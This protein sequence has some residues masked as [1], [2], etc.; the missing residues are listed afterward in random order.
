MK[1]I[2][3]SLF[4]SVTSFY[5]F[6]QPD[7]C[8]TPSDLT[9][10]TTCGASTNQSLQNATAVGSPTNVAGTTNDVW[11]TFTTP[12]GITS[13]TIALSSPGSN[14]QSNAYIEAFSAG[15][16]PSGTFSGT[17]R[18]TSAA[19]TASG[20]SLSLTGLTGSTQYHFRV[21]STGNTGSGSGPSWRFSICVSY[22][23][24]PTIS[25]P[26][27]TRMKEVFQQTILA[28][29]AAGL[30][31]PWEITYEDKEDSLWMTE[32]K[33]YK[34]RKM[35]PGTGQ[36]RV[37][38]DLSNTGSFSSF[39]RT[40]TSS[41]NPWP[42]G[43]MM[44][45]AIH[46]QF[47]AA[48]NPKNFV[49]VAYVRAF[50]GA[51]PAGGTRATATNPNNGEAVK[52]DLFTT[53]VVRFDYNTTT[54]ALENPVALCDTITGSNDHN[55]GRLVIAPVDGTDYLFYSVGD[56]GAGQFYS[57]ERT[58]KS[59]MTNSYEGKILRFSLEQDLTESGLD[60]WIP[61]DNPYNNIAPVTGKSAVYSI[62][63]RNVQGLAYVNNMLFGSSHGPFSDDEVNVLLREKHYGHPRIIGYKDGNYNNARA[64][65]ASFNGWG[66]EF[67]GS[68]LISSLPLITDEANTTLTNFQAPIFSFFDAP[69]GSSGTSGT[70]LNLYS[71][72]PS[73]SGWP[74]IAPSGMGAYTDT[75]IPGWKNSLLLASLKRGYMMRLKPNTA[76]TDVEDIGGSDTAA[77]FNTQNR[78][79]DMA[80]DPDG[81]SIYGAIDR[82]GSTSG[83]TSTTPVSSTCAGCII[84]YTFL[85]YNH[86]GG[87]S[88]I[89]TSIPIDG[90]TLNNCVTGTSVTINP[91]NLNSSIWVPLTGPDGNIVAEINA[92]GNDLGNVTSSFYTRTGTPV[93]STA[94]NSKYLN[95]NVTINVQNQPTSN[96]S[97]RL[98][99]TSQEL[100][101]MITATGGTV[102]GI[103]DIGIFKNN[104]GCGS[105][106]TASTTSQTITGR[107][108]HGSFG[109]AIQADISSF[110]TFYF[111]SSSSS[112]PA[113]V[114]TFKA[115][116]VGDASKLQWTVDAQENVEQYIL[117]RSINNI[118]FNSIGTVAAKGSV[119]EK[120]DY[121]FTDIN[122]AA[123][124][125]TVYYRIKIQ[126]KDGSYKYTSVVPVTFERFTDAFVTVQPNPV[127]NNASLMIYT[128]TD[129]TAQLR[130]VDNTGRAVINRT[131]Q[132]IKGKNTVEL[133]VSSLQSGLY[134]VDV[135]GK[136]INQKTKLIKQ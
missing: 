103:N 91:T 70:V 21:F 136:T 112:L 109:H 34:I 125:T 5:S 11:Y 10:Q 75:K 72:N 120:I 31:S 4:L 53:F 105:T 27:P 134:Y 102:S 128:N 3:F 130:I 115:V 68:P 15:S 129:E 26:N 133:N 65:T 12:A 41:Q 86:S 49:Y 124:A 50:V 74:S 47:L 14:V 66:G 57:S 99:L 93:R 108:S 97:V 2:L 126:D 69:N 95:R 33:T 132:L 18:G 110:S 58:I 94:G 78:F 135:T 25:G 83:P 6:A 122:A 59:E 48:S 81:W 17:S 87:T 96:V 89:P 38:L 131:I 77:V 82:S 37:I 22:T 88:T 7:A 51:G 101:D 1:R 113:N 29:N 117:E 116:A 24:L 55:S 62:G 107:Y 90:G 60:G 39:R 79:R 42:Q 19:T 30:D 71:T 35:S 121:L 64:A 9:P 52:G 46:P 106:L 23:A 67:S 32:N 76:G 13:V 118:S 56:M 16:C 63:H 61:D 85:G 36:S 100:Q 98:Y 54:K 43:G 119:N 45:F 84:K 8:N 127:V 104:D 44:G 20:T 123:I 92:N 73:N 28:N 80:F 111:M 114:I 40:F